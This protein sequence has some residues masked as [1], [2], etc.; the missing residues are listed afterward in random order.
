M[1]ASAL[2]LVISVGGCPPDF[3]AL[4]FQVVG[5]RFSLL[6]L[7]ESVLNEALRSNN[8]FKKTVPLSQSRAFEKCSSLNSFFLSPHHP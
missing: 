2:F 7:G 3:Q 1:E 8:N 6:A 5:Y 4:N